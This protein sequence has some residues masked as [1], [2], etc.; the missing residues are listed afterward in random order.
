MC[1]HMCTC[2]YAACTCACTAC[3][4]LVLLERQE[5]LVKNRAGLSFHHAHKCPIGLTCTLEKQTVLGS[6]GKVSE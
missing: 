1:M 6:S 2:M 3:C 5:L 4:E